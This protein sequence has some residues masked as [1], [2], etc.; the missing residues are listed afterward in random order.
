DAFIVPAVVKA[1]VEKIVKN[2][3]DAAGPL[4]SLENP[5]EEGNE[6]FT[7]Y[8]IRGHY[9]KNDALKSYF[10][11][12]MWFGRR[13]F[14]VKDIDKTL[15]AILMTRTVASA[16]QMKKLESVDSM[17]T[18]M[19]GA[20][21]DYTVSDY[22]RKINLEVFGDKM[23]KMDLLVKN[24]DE[25]VKKYQSVAVKILP[26]PRI[27]STQTGLGK[28]QEQRI[29]ETAG[30]K[31]LGQRFTWDAYIFGQLTSPSVG[32]NENPR[33][34]PSA[35]DAMQLLGS[36]AA[37]K[38]M[39]AAQQKKKWNNYDT[40][41]V[42]L[43]KEIEGKI[44]KETT[45]YDAWL[46]TLK[47]LFVNSSK[48]LFAIS[49]PWGYKNLNAALGSW[50]ELKHDTILYAEQV[51]AEM[52][53]E[54]EEFRVPAYVAPDPKGYIEPNPEFFKRAMNLAKGISEKLA[55]AGFMPEEY[56]G[57]M[58][59]FA[60]ISKTAYEIAAKEVSGAEILPDDY[61]SIVTLLNSFN[62]SLLL[63]DE[64]MYTENRDD[65]Q[66]ALIADIATD[67]VSGTVLEVATGVPQRMIVCVKDPFGGTRLTHGYVYSWYQFP[68]SKRM[69][70]KEWKAIVYGNIDA[71]KQL[72]DK[73]P[74]WYGKFLK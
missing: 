21:D 74:D 66:M 52:G 69:S 61:S 58:S 49:E 15:S 33:N 29:R 57:K 50:T 11:A 27:V 16:G 10:R 6:D 64:Q 72:K 36:T 51:Y 59:I 44:E 12:M 47:T 35:L 14:P 22:Y 70:D 20:T 38:E 24:T 65:L 1:D 34:L 63:G 54:Q 37:K 55:A 28:D 8:K 18:Y 67:A 4:P 53:G 13:S 45:F 31:F 48:Q 26:P 3:N 43:E 71:Q 39:T 2:I 17:L 32:S 25:I 9:E 42:K 5:I 23:P 73:T 7:Q 60:D 68:S 30:F 40:Q 19:V 46:G 41:V 62:S 56:A